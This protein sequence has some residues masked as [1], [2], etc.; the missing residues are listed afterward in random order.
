MKSVSIYSKCRKTYPSTIAFSVF[1]LNTNMCFN[2]NQF[3]C[4]GTQTSQII[5]A[6]KTKMICV[7]NSGTSNGPTKYTKYIAVTKRVTLNEKW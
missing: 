5:R 1:K 2:K 4:H 3:S 7:Y 6:T